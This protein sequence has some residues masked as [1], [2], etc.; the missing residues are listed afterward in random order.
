LA[1]DDFEVR[2]R[3]GATHA[4]EAMVTVLRMHGCITPAIS[5]QVTKKII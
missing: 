4:C 5:E 3:L 1:A 2:K